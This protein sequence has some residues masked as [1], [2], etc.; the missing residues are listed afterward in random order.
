MS[1][2]KR[3]R[4]YRGSRNLQ[5]PLELEGMAKLGRFGSFHVRTK[6]IGSGTMEVIGLPVLPAGHK[7]VEISFRWPVLFAGDIPL[8]FVIQGRCGDLTANVTVVKIEKHEFR[9]MG[10]LGEL[11]FVPLPVALKDHPLVH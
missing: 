5:F 7:L 4:M 3:D 10:K 2:G 6:Q 9:T 1:T 8:Q 11:P